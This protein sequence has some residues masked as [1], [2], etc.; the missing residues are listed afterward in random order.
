VPKLHLATLYTEVVEIRSPT[1][2]TEGG[3][4]ELELQ[5]DTDLMRKEPSPRTYFFRQIGFALASAIRETTVPH[6]YW[7]VEFEPQAR[8][9][10]NLPERQKLKI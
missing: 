8:Q 10:F 9:M 6:E 5:I 2:P 3:Q 1:E 4:F 7:W